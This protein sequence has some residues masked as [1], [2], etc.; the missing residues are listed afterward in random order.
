MILSGGDLPHVLLRP[1]D[2]D[3]IG[4]M[5][6]EPSVSRTARRIRG[7]PRSR[8]PEPPSGAPGA[9]AL[10]SGG[11]ARS[12]DVLD[13]DRRRPL[14]QSSPRATSEAKLGD[15]PVDREQCQR[16]QEP[17][18][19]EKSSPTIESWTAFEED[20]GEVERR[21]LPELALAGEPEP[22]EDA[23]YTRS[24]LTITAHASVPISNMPFLLRADRQGG[25]EHL[26]TPAH[27]RRHPARLDIESS[28][29]CNPGEMTVSP[30]LARRRRAWT[31]PDAR[32]G[33]IRSRPRPRPS[34]AAAD[35]PIP[36]S[37]PPTHRHRPAAEL[38]GGP[39]EGPVV[40]PQGRHE[41]LERAFRYAE[42]AHEGQVRPRGSRTSN[43]RSR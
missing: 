14:D 23:A 21:H 11:A 34:G 2:G 5:L 43:I 25:Y 32:C 38:H 42:E 30:T 24:V 27:P 12:P 15:D 17:P 16:G 36:A 29:P 40:Q 20:D 19:S 39:E 28:P 18:W 9:Q 41:A 35:F 10:P 13:E 3:V 4:T 26:G 31:P 1:D 22:D 37:A 33:S 7:D 6:I 8:A